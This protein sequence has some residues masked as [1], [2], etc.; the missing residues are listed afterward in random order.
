MS[1]TLMAVSGAACSTGEPA[2]SPGTTSSPGKDGGN[3]AEATAIRNVDWRN[4][5][6]EIVSPKHHADSWAGLCFPGEVTFQNAKTTRPAQG[7]HGT[8]I[9]EMLQ[10]TAKPRE[11]FAPV[12]G[13][14]TGDGKEEAV[15]YLSCTDNRT[16]TNC[17]GATVM[18]AAAGKLTTLDYAYYLPEEDETDCVP[19]MH[20]YRLDGRKLVVDTS[21]FDG[22]THKTIKVTWTYRWDGSQLKRD[23]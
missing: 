13:D 14:L 7:D 19:T 6:I 15:V 16:G 2:G 12:Y 3:A 5:T 22:D 8:Q 10:D 21:Y 1:A 20:S 18:S 11:K 4:A 9:Q 23:K 17:G